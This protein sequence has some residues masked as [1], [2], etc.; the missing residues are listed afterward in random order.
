MAESKAGCAGPPVCTVET[1]R[2]LPDE[3]ILLLR[4]GGSRKLLIRWISLPV[5]NR[6]TSHKR[7]ILTQY[8]ESNR[9]YEWLRDFR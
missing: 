4:G 6:C 9:L 7:L 1:V 3:A 8:H 2:K 5:P